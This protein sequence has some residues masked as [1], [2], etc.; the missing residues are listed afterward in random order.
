MQVIPRRIS[1]QFL[2]DLEHEDGIL[3]PL[4]KSVRAAGRLSL[5][6]RK[7][8]INIYYLGG[9][10]LCIRKSKNGYIGTMDPKYGYDCD[11]KVILNSRTDAI[12]VAKTFPERCEAILART[13]TTR[14]KGLQQLLYLTNQ[15]GDFIIVDTEIRIPKAVAEKIYGHEHLPQFD[16]VGLKICDNGKYRPVLIENKWGNKNLSGK[17]GLA[18]H[19]KDM[20]KFINSEYFRTYLQEL[21]IQTNQMGSLGLGNKRIDNQIDFNDCENKP[22][23]LFIFG[24]MGKIDKEWFEKLMRP[25]KNPGID[26]NYLALPKIND[27]WDYIGATKDIF[28]IK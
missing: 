1:E 6:I 9:N 4:L 28:L 19:A 3:N 8:Y 23:I 14:E 13:K 26:I 21:E 16:M 15:S 7:D 11:N 18:E 10:V 17:A 24:N 12:A 20:T 27:P 5:Q 22:E 25:V 2:Y